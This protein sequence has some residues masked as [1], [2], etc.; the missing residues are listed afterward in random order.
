MSLFLIKTFWVDAHLVE[1]A[2][3]FGDGSIVN[4]AGVPL[5]VQTGRTVVTFSR[6][7]LV[8]QRNAASRKFSALCRRGETINC[9]GVNAG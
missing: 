2:Y 5:D 9:I 6:K 8:F 1:D 7:K 4:N 3:E